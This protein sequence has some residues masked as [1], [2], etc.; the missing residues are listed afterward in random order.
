VQPYKLFKFDINGALIRAVLE[1]VFG[2]YV[3]EEYGFNKDDDIYL[4]LMSLCNKKYIRD[5]FK[6]I[7]IAT[8]YN[9]SIS[10]YERFYYVESTIRRFM[11]TIL[12]KNL[13][14]DNLNEIL[15]KYITNTLKPI[16]DKDGNY[17]LYLNND[18]GFGVSMDKIET[19]KGLL[20]IEIIVNKGNK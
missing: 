20:N 8:I 16:F 3:Y 12:D 18:G 7:I 4:S 14:T 17:L 9:G 6:K 13:T 10:I 19:K 11:Q 2:E 1:Y 5:D 15:G